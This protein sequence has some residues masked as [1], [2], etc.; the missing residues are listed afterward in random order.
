MK[1]FSLVDSEVI[2]GSF[3]NKVEILA[4]RQTKGV[5]HIYGRLK[6]RKDVAMN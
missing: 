5:A 1:L 3:F 6:E 2:Q 4:V